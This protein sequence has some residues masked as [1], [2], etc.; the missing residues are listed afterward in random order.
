MK[1]DYGRILS[2]AVFKGL[3]IV[4][5]SALG[6]LVALCSPQALCHVMAAG[7]VRFTTYLMMDENG[8]FATDSNGE[9]IQLFDEKGNLLAYNDDVVK[10]LKE[11][12]NDDGNNLAA[13][14]REFFL[15]DGK[16]YLDEAGSMELTDLSKVMPAVFKYD[17]LQSGYTLQAGN[18]TVYLSP[19]SVQGSPVYV[20]RVAGTYEKLP[21]FTVSSDGDIS[22]FERGSVSD[23]SNEVSFVYDSNYF[24]DENLSQ[25]LSLDAAV[26][27]AGG[28]NAPMFAGY[29]VKNTDGRRQFI[30]ID[31]SI[32]LSAGEYRDISNGHADAEYCYAVRLY[33]DGADTVTLY[34][35]IDSGSLYSDYQR[36][37]GF[38]NIGGDMLWQL[39]YDNNPARGHFAGYYAKGAEEGS[40]DRFIDESGNLTDGSSGPQDENRE[41]SARFYH[42]VSADGANVY[43]SDGKVYSDSALTNEISNIADVTGGIPEDT[44]EKVHSDEKNMDGIAKRYFIGYYFASDFWE[45]EE[46][47]EREM[48]LSEYEEEGFDP[49]NVEISKIRFADRAGNIVFNGAGAPDFDQ[50]MTVFQNWYTVTVWDDGEVE[51]ED[52]ADE[53]V[54]DNE[55][56]EEGDEEKT[57]G[58]DAEASKE[59]ADESK[60]KDAEKEGEDKDKPAADDKD[61]PAGGDTQNPEGDPAAIDKGSDDSSAAQPGSEDSKDGE[62]S[63]NP[64]DKKEGVEENAKPSDKEQGTD[65]GNAENS[66]D[67]GDD[68]G[69][70]AGSDGS[71]GSSE[72]S[73]SNTAD[74]GGNVAVVMSPPESNEEGEGN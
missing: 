33:A 37:N 70:D 58:E 17:G 53:T 35:D 56:I 19:L 2:R 11:H 55:A 5:I 45:N 39:S 22:Y 44:E 66:G 59:G 64:E 68:G 34:S 41:Y 54:K 32:V 74:S 4:S 24:Y 40:F 7:P 51:I 8:E 38:D 21:A 63:D 9:Y 43:F 27:D 60:E 42:I 57:E 48:L 50:D 46:D 6:C 62:G 14:E 49:A 3:K 61:K 72:N 10:Y 16:L 26:P 71:E 13:K 47:S 12:S 28:D 1:K 20:A 65:D 15:I 29:Y 23:G 73:S 30:D 67:G 36:M 31:G 25:L 52:K 18:G 69:S